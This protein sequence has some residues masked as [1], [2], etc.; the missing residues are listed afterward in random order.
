MGKNTNQGQGT[1]FFFGSIGVILVL[2]AVISYQK[3]SAYSIPFQLCL[4]IGVS[5]LTISIVEYLW[6][7]KGGDPIIKAINRLWKAISCLR[8]VEESGIDKIYIQRGKVNL[9]DWI[10]NIS[11]AKEVDAMGINLATIISKR[12][13]LRKIIIDRAVTKKCK[14]RILVLDPA[15]PLTSQ[16]AE[17]EANQVSIL[18]HGTLIQRFFANIRGSLL[19]FQKMREE[20][21]KTIK[22]DTADRFYAIRVINK[23]NIY[24]SIIR[25][26]DKMLVTKYLSHLTGTQSPSFELRLPKE[27]ADSPIE[28]ENLFKT[29]QDE[30]EEMWK[31]ATDW[32]VG[33]DQF[34]EED[35]HRIGKL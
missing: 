28:G 25:T 14:F 22:K 27:Q 19:T 11:T 5:I 26:D 23:S 18:D 13:Q 10:N 34:L 12:P 17:E 4:N 31:I 6:K 30:F 3:G 16:R 8:D 2:I 7:I 35:T 15:S 21:C 33:N 9:D 20:I 1:Y 29:F 32:P 24:C